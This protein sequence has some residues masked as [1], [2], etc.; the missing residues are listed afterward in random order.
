MFLLGGWIFDWGFEWLLLMMVVEC[1]GM[2][3]GRRRGK[4]GLCGLF[5]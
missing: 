5:S 4:R 3:K 2:L 1:F